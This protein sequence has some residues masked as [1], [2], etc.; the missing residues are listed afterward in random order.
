MPYRDIEP[1]W[2]NSKDKYDVLDW[3]NIPPFTCDMNYRL[4]QQH[5]VSGFFQCARM[6]LIASVATVAVQFTLKLGIA[7]AFLGTA[8]TTFVVI[9]AAIVFCFP[10]DPEYRR[11]QDRLA[12]AAGA[13]LIWGFLAFVALV[14]SAGE[15]T[16]ATF[17]VGTLCISFFADRIATHHLHWASA[18]P[19]V[20]RKTMTSWRRDWRAR[21][22]GFSDKLPSNQCETATARAAFSLILKLR[23][24]YPLGFLTVVVVLL[25]AVSVASK[26]NHADFGNRNGILVFL[27]SLVG[28]SAVSAA[29]CVLMPDSPKAFL[30]AVGGAYE[31]GGS[32]PTPAWVFHSPLGSR[33]TRR[34]MIS[35][36]TATIVSVYSALAFSAF[37]SHSPE[38]L[39]AIVGLL[40][41]TLVLPAIGGPAILILGSFVAAAP[42]IV[43]H[44]RA[45]NRVGA[46]EHHRDWSELDGYIQRV[47]N[48]RNSIERRHNIVG[49]HA[50]GKYPILAD[51]DL[52][53][54]HQHVLGPTGV[55]KTAL[56]LTTDVI[57]AIR[58]G[59]G[60]SIIIDCKGDRALFET[61]RLEAERAG[62]TFKWFTNKPGRST[63]LF[64]PLAHLNDPQFTLPEILG[65][66]LQSL[67][68]YHGDDY[69]RAY[70][71]KEVRTLLRDAYLATMPDEQSRRGIGGGRR[72][73]REGK[74]ESFWDLDDV[75]KELAANSRQ[76][77]AA[78][79]LSMIVQSLCDF[80]QLSL[81]PSRDPNETAIEHA[82]SMPEA[83]EEKQVL[84]FYLV[85][86][87]DVASVG[88]LARL[89]LFAANAAAIKYRDRTN[90]KPRIQFIADE[91]QCLVAKNIETVLQQARDA[92]IAFTFAHQ[93][94]SQ[95]KLPGGV[96]LTQQVL[97]STCIKR[98]HAARDPASQKYIS[99]ISGTT[100]Y[101]SR[102]W[103]QFKKR[104]DAGIVSSRYACTD[105]D[106]V[107]RI[108][109]SEHVGPRLE[110]EDIRDINRDINKSIAIF[111]RNSGYSQYCGAFPMV[112][113]W[114][115]SMR[116][117]VKRSRAAWPE[118]QGETISIGGAW[119]G[120]NENTIAPTTHPEIDLTVDPANLD[121]ALRKIHQKLTGDDSRDENAT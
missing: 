4:P 120:G 6:M 3:A 38:T 61:A 91:A 50:T 60:P 67:N 96:D 59:D 27:A 25:C 7:S 117:H 30:S 100:T 57:Q 14:N 16:V 41:F 105:P 79:H 29:Y 49:I 74:I 24:M 48:S 39:N 90:E 63:Y 47:Q 80:E 98:Y 20:D 55:G 43:A 101:Y 93:S 13:F 97:N 18:N 15:A 22:T 21:W 66:I 53:F 114:P 44:H 115:V 95:L 10:V 54:E 46:V 51:T 33:V 103:K 1:T 23:K 68:L 37:S 89:A 111:E 83:I 110:P 82:I 40:G 87:L 81:T 109:I 107:M 42:T 26:M 99:D 113:E 8:S 76:Y 94:L 92:G 9:V 28:L 64:N 75:L 106:G 5:G 12:S 56:S 112:T 88:E 73:R 58:R 84:Y 34:L 77:E 71:G 31:Y 17:V 116:E 36:I 45:L 86:S 19:L 2:H 121:E 85:G 11:W 78:K 70:F 119:P 72:F 32:G 102:K 108:D 52:Q 104:I 69:A 65:V 118:N 62:R 35:V